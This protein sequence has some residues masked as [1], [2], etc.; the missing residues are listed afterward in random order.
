MAKQFVTDIELAWSMRGVLYVKASPRP[1]TS[2]RVIVMHGFNVDDEAVTRD[3]QDFLAGLK[4]VASRLEPTVETLQ[5]PGKFGYAQAVDLATATYPPVVAD[6]LTDLAANHRGEVVFIAHSLGCRLILETLLAL[7]PVVQA[8]LLPRTRLFLMAA[9]VPTVLF[10]QPRYRHLANA[11]RR[12]DVL[13]SHSDAVLRLAFP[14]GQ[15]SEMGRLVEA[16]GLNGQPVSVWEP[17]RR[18]MRGYGHGDYWTD[19]MTV[20]RLAQSLGA[21]RVRPKVSARPVRRKAAVRAIPSRWV[22]AR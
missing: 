18:R 17:Q 19:P 1:P 5:W 16:V 7:P 2:R 15:F 12:I 13:Y 21:E 20:F 10:D 4:A 14:A 8:N 9:A 6:F 22:S 3:Y 11:C